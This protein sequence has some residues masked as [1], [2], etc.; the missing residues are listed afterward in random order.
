M[1]NLLFSVYDKKDFGIFRTYCEE[2]V[3]NKGKTIPEGET[4][5]VP[6][7]D[8]YAF[9]ICSLCYYDIVQPTAFTSEHLPVVLKPDHTDVICALYSDRMPNTFNTAIDEEEWASFA[10]VATHRSDIYETRTCHSPIASSTNR[11]T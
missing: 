5:Y 7:D 3:C 8:D 9:A 1:V 4:V 2:H 11:S 10:Q 6:K